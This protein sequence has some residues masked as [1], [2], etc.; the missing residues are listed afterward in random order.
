MAALAAFTDLYGHLSLRTTANPADAAAFLRQ[1]VADIDRG[2]VLAGLVGRRQSLR[3]L[4][5]SDRRARG[6]TRPAAG[7]NAQHH[8]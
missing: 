5:K 8:N 2:A 4:V 3:R 6:T 7:Q 1:I